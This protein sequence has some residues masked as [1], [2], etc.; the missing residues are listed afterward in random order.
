MARD[1]SGGTTT[2]ETDVIIKTVVPLIAALGYDVNGNDVEHDKAIAIGRSKYV[3]P[4]IV[5][6]IDGVPA[7]VIDGKR[8]TE[9]I[10]HY[11]RQIL[12]YGLLL[13]TPYS[14]LTNGVTFRVYETYTERVVWEQPMARL[15]AFLSKSKLAKKIHKAVDAVTDQQI[16]EAKK[17]LLVFEGIK[18]FA[19]LLEKCEDVIRDIDGLTGADAFDEISKLL[20]MKMYYEK[21]ADKTGKH[22]VQTANIKAHGGASYVKDFLFGKVVKANTD[23]FIGDEKIELD[24]KSID[25]IIALLESYT[26]INTDIDVKGRAFEIFLGKTFTG[27]LGQFFT[28]RTIVRFTVD[29]ADPEISSTIGSKGAP[30]LVIDPACGSGG[31][32][33]EVFKNVAAKIGNQPK[34]RQAD[35]FERLSKH[36]I[37]G[38]DINPRLVRVAKMNMVLHGDGHGG[39]Y[40]ANGLLGSEHIKNAGRGQF[41]LVIT[42]PPFGNKDKGKLLEAFELGK[43]QGR[44]I[45]EQIRE[46]LFVEQCIQLAKPAGELAILLP[47]GILNNEQLGYV[48]DY[49]RKHTVITAIIS[50]PDGAFKA[51]GANSK[52]S[53]L[54]LKRRRRQTEPQPPVFMAVADEIG[55]DR[56]TKEARDIEQNDLHAILATYRTYKASKGYEN[57]RRN[58]SVVKV[59]HD[60]PACFLIG[61]RKLADR[62]DATYYY[63]RDVFDLDRATCPVHTYARLSRVIVNPQKE[64][65]KSIRYIQFSNVE[66]RLGSIV[67]YEE[68][69]GGDAPS[70]AKQ[71]VQRGDIISARVKDSEENVAIVADEFD[72]C[73]VSTGFIVTQPI[74]PMTS[75]ALYVLLRLQTTLNQVRWKSSGTIMASISDAEYLT[76]KIPKLSAAQIKILTEKVRDVEK[77]RRSIRHVLQNLQQS[78]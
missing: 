5:I 57:L 6:N 75:E 39:I 3:Y 46:V 12:S 72:G 24:N 4:D 47:D 55:Y 9:N 45:E 61:E 22:E 68:L 71:A 66:Q 17:T 32:L 21:Q 69:L 1:A 49:I 19:S 62:L 2:S 36:Q 31:F 60:K 41:D 33:I 15:P 52:C 53:L 28:P 51:S 37:F 77:Q 25:K 29:F 35:L 13:K 42:N 64:P 34:N 70:R 18:E 27:G 44:P 56:R 10:D 20:F 73:I 7:V 14:A 67:S 48:R 76:I 23:I 26:L 63:A 74:P 8:T 38:L 58:A 40:K 16:E 50:L 59:L 11:E 30:Y 78:V 54:F 43:K 65:L